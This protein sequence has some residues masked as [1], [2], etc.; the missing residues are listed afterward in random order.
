MQHIGLSINGYPKVIEVY[1]L[2]VGWEQDVTFI[3]GR[4]VLRAIFVWMQLPASVGPAVMIHTVVSSRVAEDVENGNGLQWT[5]DFQ[6]T[7][8]SCEEILE[9]KSRSVLAAFDPQES[10]SAASFSGTSFKTNCC[11]LG[12][13]CKSFLSDLSSLFWCVCSFSILISMGRFFCSAGQW[14]VM[15]RA[16]G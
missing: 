3:S 16:V 2:Q 6:N 11:L 7:L 15:A 13:S 10:C 9:T 4:C 12:M 5:A 1:H 14:L 8:A